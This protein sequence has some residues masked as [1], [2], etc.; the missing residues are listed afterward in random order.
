MTT[1]K[2]KPKPK[3]APKTRAL[4]GTSTAVH[5]LLQTAAARGNFQAFTRAVDAAGLR[6]TLAGPGP[7]T[8]FAPT[9]EAFAAL[10]EGKL[11][12]LMRPENK[13][14]LAS[15]VS[16]H[17]MTGRKTAKEMG[18]WDSARTV[19]GLLASLKMVGKQVSIEGAQVTAP[20]I[21]ASNGYLHGIDQV[22]LPVPPR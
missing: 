9:D 3:P 14:E 5:D 4:P 21:D 1:P 16:Y 22:M 7:F 12:E 18:R 20:D 19:N 8:V 2:P 15:V 6:P 13:T 17:V 11:E 10:P